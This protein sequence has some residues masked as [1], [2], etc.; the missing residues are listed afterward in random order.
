MGISLK[1][2]AGAGDDGNMLMLWRAKV[3]SSNFGA[4]VGSM[5]YKSQVAYP[6]S[7]VAALNLEFMFHDNHAGEVDF[8]YLRTQST[9]STSLMKRL[10]PSELGTAQ[11]T[12]VAETAWLENTLKSKLDCINQFRDAWLKLQAGCD[13]KGALAVP[14]SGAGFVDLGRESRC[15]R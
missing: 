8:E 4:A 9:L 11:A 6:A 12:C 1:T 13:E 10:C 5:K 2:S 7:L 3:R 14:P 15:V